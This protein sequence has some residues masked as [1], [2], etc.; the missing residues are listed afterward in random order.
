MVFIDFKIWLPTKKK[1]KPNGPPKQ[2]KSVVYTKIKKNKK[3]KKEKN[4]RIRP[5]HFGSA[6]LNKKLHFR[7]FESES[8][9]LNLIFSFQTTKI[10]FFPVMV[11]TY[12]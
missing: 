3:E 5:K 4:S 12:M 8:T 11:I 2:P 1:I 7:V 6:N 10:T 9:Y